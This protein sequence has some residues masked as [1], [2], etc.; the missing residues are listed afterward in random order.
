[1]P[2]ARA[3]RIDIVS[4]LVCPWCWVGRR[5]LQEAL[6]SLKTEIE[7]RIV[8]H[9]F[10]LRPDTP[11]EGFVKQPD[12]PSNP[13]VGAR[14]RAAGQAVGIDFTGKS[15]IRPNTLPAHAALKF[16]ADAEARGEAE[17]GTQDRLNEELFCDYFTRGVVA[18]PDAVAAAAGR[19]GLDAD[20]VRKHCADQGAQRVVAQEAQEWSRRGVSGVPT[21][22]FNGREAFSGAQDASLFVR[23]LRQA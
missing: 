11:A 9:P 15:D 22:Y 4:D 6:D 1:M 2:A 14:L 21:F 7:A 20:L 12:T 18:T 19:V 23:A 3:V 16:A 17:S 5:K 13:R 8:W 10:L